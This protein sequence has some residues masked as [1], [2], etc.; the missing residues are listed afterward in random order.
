M[1]KLISDLVSSLTFPTLRRKRLKFGGAKYLAD[2]QD[3]VR[4]RIQLRIPDSVLNHSK[5]VMNIKT[6]CGKLLKIVF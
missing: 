2:Q 3:M 1:N 4:I 5:M 6:F